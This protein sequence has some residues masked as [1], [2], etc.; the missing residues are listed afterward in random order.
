M[1]NNDTKLTPTNILN[2]SYDPALDVI[3]VEQ[4]GADGVLKNPAT[5][6][7]Q[8]DEITEIKKLVGFDVNDDITT[9]I[10]TVGSVV[11]IAETDGAKTLT[12][13]IDKTDPNNKSITSVWS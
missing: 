10:V 6:A 1:S 12:T 9:T 3:I 5:E 2:R 11:T 4:I 7:K 13:T 8:D